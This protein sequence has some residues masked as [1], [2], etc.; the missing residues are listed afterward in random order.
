LNRYSTIVV[1]DSLLKSEDI[2]K[3]IEQIK[4][5]ITNN[6]GEILEIDRW[7]KKRLAYI[8]KKRQYGFYIEIIF[9][10]NGSVIKVIEREYGLDENILRFLTIKFDKKMLQYYEQAK[11]QRSAKV[12]GEGLVEDDK[13]KLAEQPN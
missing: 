5:S 12:Q 7:G 9:N 4:R 2:E 8:I 1:I 11:A 6:G 3:T 13:I 10:A